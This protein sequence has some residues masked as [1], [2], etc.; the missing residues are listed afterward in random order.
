M[1]G[2]QALAESVWET[3]FRVL[4][5]TQTATQLLTDDDLNHEKPI[6]LLGNVRTEKSGPHKDHFNLKTHG[7]V[8]LIN[9]MRIYAISHG[10]R[11]PSTLG[12]LKRLA[13]KGVFSKDTADLLQTGFETLMMFKI[14]T[15]VEKLAAA[16]APDNYIQPAAMSRK[17]RNLLKD[18]LLSVVQMQKM[19]SSDFSSAWS[20][21]FS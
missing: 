9:G 8:H 14:K 5:R 17:Q 16:R 3:V 2:N 12:R 11:E 7:L 21:F 13:A 20:H 18:A 4:D 19:I 15:N 6:G 1:W 10:I